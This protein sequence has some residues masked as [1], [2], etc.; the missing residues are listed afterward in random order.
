MR[1]FRS[2]PYFPENNIWTYSVKNW[3]GTRAC[4]ILKFIF[5]EKKASY[6][7]NCIPRF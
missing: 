6:K 4:Y 3:F 5:L 7:E 1:S 2:S